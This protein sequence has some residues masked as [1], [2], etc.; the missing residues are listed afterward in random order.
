M[1]QPV[2]YQ[3]NADPSAIWGLVGSM[4]TAAGVGGYHVIRVIV[5]NRKVR[6]LIASGIASLEDSS[7]GDKKKS[8]GD[9]TLSTALLQFLHQQEADRQADRQ[10]R[11]RQW[12]RIE[13]MLEAIRDLSAQTRELTVG[14]QSASQHFNQVHAEHARSIS[15]IEE[16]QVNMAT[17][18]YQNLSGMRF[19]QQP[20]PPPQRSAG[21]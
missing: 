2:Q 15:R 20:P 5:R 8:V 17:W 10:E 9:G 4:I 1:I 6:S 19:A 14:L 7:D 18:V 16:S 3:I 13:E 21:R 12:E 11:G